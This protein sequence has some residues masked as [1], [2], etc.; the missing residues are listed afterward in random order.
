MIS[1]D[2]F[3]KS[4]LVRSLPF[5]FRVSTISF[6]YLTRVGGPSLK[7]PQFSVDIICRHHV[8]KIPAVQGQKLPTSATVFL[9]TSSTAQGGGGS[10]RI[11]NL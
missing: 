4:L 7:P 8:T 2:P 5:N 11:G 1:M 10:F 6:S 9:H 3:H